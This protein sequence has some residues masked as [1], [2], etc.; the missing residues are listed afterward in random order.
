MRNAA[1][2]KKMPQLGSDNSS[3]VQLIP[4]PAF[5]SKQI[6]FPLQ[7]TPISV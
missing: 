5:I 3:I 4:L 2:F 6:T 1:I 7:L